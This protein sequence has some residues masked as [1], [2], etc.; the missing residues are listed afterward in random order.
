M[1][2]YTIKPIAKKQKGSGRLDDRTGQDRLIIGLREL[3][4]RVRGAVAVAEARV[5][6]DAG[7]GEDG[8]GGEE[9][10]PGD[11]IGTEEDFSARS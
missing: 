10:K 4:V 5:E 8:E 9:K 1:T 6:G 7:K 11:I 3:A 2:F